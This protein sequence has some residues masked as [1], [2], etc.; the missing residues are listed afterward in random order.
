MSYASVLI[1]GLDMA[2]GR[3]GK[4]YPWGSNPVVSDSVRRKR[5]A[6]EDAA[7][8]QAAEAMGDFRDR[9]TIYSSYLIAAGWSFLRQFRALP[10]DDK[11][12]ALATSA[13]AA[14]P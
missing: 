10:H 9:I 11:P 1:F 5:F 12:I 13:A 6:K 3:D 8:K 4:L 14:S 7:L 2:P